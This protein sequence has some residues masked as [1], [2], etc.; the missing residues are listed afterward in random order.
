M[1]EKTAGIRHPP[2]NESIDMIDVAEYM[3][4][5]DVQSFISEANEEYYHWNDIFHRDLPEEVGSEELWFL[6]KFVRDTDSTKLNIDNLDLKYTRTDWIMEKLHQFDK[7]LGGKYEATSIIPEDDKRS[8]LISAIMEEAIASSQLE[9]AT[10]SREDAKKMLRRDEE[11]SDKSEKMILNNYK[12]IQ[13][14]KELKD[15]KLTPQLLK[16]LH[17]RITKNT[18]EKEEYEGKFRDG[19]MT[20]HDSRHNEVVHRAPD[21]EKAQEMIESLCEF[22][23]N[24]QKFIHP[25]IKASIIH[26]SIGYIHPFHD[27]NGRTAR[28]VFYWY[29]VKEGYERVEYLSISRIIKNKP[30]QYRDA[31]VKSETDEN[32][33]TYF[34]KFQFQVLDEAL[35]ELEKYIEKRMQEKEQLYS[36]QKLEGIN[37]RQVSALNE[38]AEDPQRMMTIKEHAN[39]FDI[40]YEAAR[41]D[42]K[43]LEEKEILTSKKR[44]RKKTYFRSDSFNEKIKEAKN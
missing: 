20:V 4:R 21:A 34:I 30:G 1:V 16:E 9:G 43:E 18:L 38:F 29:L 27:G 44:G 42:L 17:E 41:L 8:Y 25:L 26:F 5:E 24:D 22:A 39:T 40:S 33:I 31:Y 7:A 32:D 23:E 28:A 35:D 2:E 11:P 10:S 36:F 3:S 13:K 6:V 14:I 15:R 12:T 37:E 19:S